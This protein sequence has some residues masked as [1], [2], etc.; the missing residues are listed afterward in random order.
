MSS[1]ASVGRSLKQRMRS[2]ERRVR[3]ADPHQLSAV[4]AS[5]PAARSA[6][7]FPHF[8]EADFYAAISGLVLLGGR[9][10]A[11][12]LIARQW[13][14][15]RP[16]IRDSLIRLNRFAKVGR[17]PV[18]RSGGDWLSSHGPTSLHAATVIR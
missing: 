1:T 6:H 5:G 11:Y 16:Y 13:R 17:H 8:I 3:A 15:T 10:P 4:R 9:D 12:P 7:A 2:I 18:H 14:N